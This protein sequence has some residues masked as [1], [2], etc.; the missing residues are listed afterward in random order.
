MK[1][2]AVVALSLIVLASFASAEV[3]DKKDLDVPRKTSAVWTSSWKTTPGG[4]S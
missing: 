3:I 1:K 2:G 4:G